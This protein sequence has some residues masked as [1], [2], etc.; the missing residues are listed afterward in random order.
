MRFNPWLKYNEALKFTM[1]ENQ[2]KE[3][4]QQEMYNDLF[5]TSSY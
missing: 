4:A 5:K 2:N 3:N 1:V